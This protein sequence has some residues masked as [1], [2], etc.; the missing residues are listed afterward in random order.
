LAA[1][2]KPGIKVTVT[3]AKTAAGPQVAVRDLRVEAEPLA[4]AIRAAGAEA[5]VV[6]AVSVLRQRLLRKSV[7]APRGARVVADLGHAIRSVALFLR[8]R[9]DRRLV[10]ALIVAHAGAQAPGAGELVADV[11][12]LRRIRDQSREP[13][14]LLEEYMTGEEVSVEA[15]SFRGDTTIVGITDKS[16]TGFPYF[17]EDGHMFPARLEPAVV[18]RIHGLVR[19]ALKAVGHDHGISH[20]EVK[21]TPKGPRIVEINPRPP[22]NYIVELVKRVTGI[23][24]L[25]VFTDLGLGRRPNLTPEDTGVSSAAVQFVVPQHGGFVTALGGTET[26]DHDPHVARWTMSPVAGSEIGPPID[27]ACYLGHV[28]T[29]DPHGQDARRFAEGA[30]SRI[31]LTFREAQ[32]ASLVS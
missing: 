4:E 24:L 1:V 8:Q 27:N 7:G 29:V 26:L 13:L 15:C 20:T 17:I 9:H 22:G 6:L 25:A 30:L 16:V 14:W 18:D 5:S 10:L 11:E 31:E 2:L 28:V 12:L 32:D 3:A 23:D 21:L 19:E